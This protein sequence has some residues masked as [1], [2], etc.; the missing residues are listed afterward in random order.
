MNH[1]KHTKTLCGQN[2]DVLSVGSCGEIYKT[3]QRNG[4]LLEHDFF[5]FFFLEPL[6]AR[7]MLLPALWYLRSSI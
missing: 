3:P 4:Q 5:F 7:D 1:T 2:A 6:A